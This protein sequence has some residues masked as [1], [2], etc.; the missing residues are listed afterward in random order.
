LFFGDYVY[1]CFLDT[2]TIDCSQPIT[3]L[4]SVASNQVLPWA[5]GFNEDRILIR[6][7]FKER[8]FRLGKTNSPLAFSSRQSHLKHT[9]FSLFFVKISEQNCYEKS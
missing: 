5:T 7:S 6:A 8:K 3:G 1:G 2:L 4:T 9:I